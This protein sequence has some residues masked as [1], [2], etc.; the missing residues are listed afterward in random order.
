MLLMAVVMFEASRKVIAG[1]CIGMAVKKWQGIFVSFFSNMV[2]RDRD[3]SVSDDVVQ[4]QVWLRCRGT[5]GELLQKSWRIRGQR[6]VAFH[7]Q[8]SELLLD[9][10]APNHHRSGR[11]QRKRDCHK[12]QYGIV[13]AIIRRGRR[14]RR[15]RSHNEPAVCARY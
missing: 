9:V 3:L 7:Q 14:R 10:V 13:S 6:A 5:C 4:W 2:M 1:E 11:C 15:S 12:N 8:D